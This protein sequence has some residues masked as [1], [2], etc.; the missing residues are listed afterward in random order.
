MTT[1]I[2]ELEE[3]ISKEKIAVKL[4]PL[5][6]YFYDAFKACLRNI[7]IPLAEEAPEIYVENLEKI[8]EKFQE[9]LK[10]R[11]RKIVEMAIGS[12]ICENY[13]PEL[14]NL[15]EEEREFY[16]KLKRALEDKALEKALEDK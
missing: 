11:V 10:V 14:D 3:L 13:N 6:K 5:P 16:F 8:L 12:A 7:W 4:Q 2:E 15:T 1:L 9:L